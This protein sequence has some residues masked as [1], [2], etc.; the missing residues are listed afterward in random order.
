MRVSKISAVS[1]MDNTV[2]DLPVGE[3]S[4]EIDG[5]TFKLIKS[6]TVFLT[7]TA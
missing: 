7:R 2:A 5:K 4:M 6:D 3:W 1:D